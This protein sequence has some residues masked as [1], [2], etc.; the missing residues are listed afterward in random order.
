MIHAF[1]IQI[2]AATK[3]GSDQT[4]KMKQLLDQYLPPWHIDPSG[5]SA[6]LGNIKR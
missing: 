3:D 4:N 6:S 5:N 1:K 2:L